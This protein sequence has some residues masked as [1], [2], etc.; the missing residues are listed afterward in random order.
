MS[1]PQSGL[2]AHHQRLI[3]ESAISDEVA[4]ERGYWS[5]TKPKEL[6]RWFGPTQQKLVPA[7]VIPIHNVHGEPAFCQL[8]PDRR[9]A[10]VAVLRGRGG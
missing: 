8:R 7:L 6:E 10:L 1:V 5:A 3:R 4:A 2:L 9:R